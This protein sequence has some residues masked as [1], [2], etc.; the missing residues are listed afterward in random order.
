MVAQAVSMGTRFL[1][2]TEAQFSDQYKQ[3]VVGSKAEDAIYTSL[4]DLD[5]PATHRVLRNK[6]VD[7]WEAAGLPA[8]CQRPGEGTII[9]TLDLFGTTT[10]LPKYS[11]MTPL[12]GFTGDMEYIALYAGESCSL[13][14]ES[15]RRLKS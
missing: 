8:N 15:N 3:R 4:F 10:E 7:D 1:C 6:A 14:A 9:A 2:S 5:W 12:T 13:I 11:A